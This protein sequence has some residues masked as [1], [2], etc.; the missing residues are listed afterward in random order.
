MFPFDKKPRK[1]KGFGGFTEFDGFFADFEAEMNQLMQQA[2]RF[3]ER[4]FVYGYSAYTGEDGKPVVNEYTNIPG[5]KGLNAGGQCVD[6]SCS[7]PQLTSSGQND[8]DEPYYDVLDEGDR[9]K[10][11]VDMPGVEKKDIK[12]RTHGRCITI[13]AAGEGITYGCDIHIPDYV[14]QKPQ[15]TSYKNGILEIT[16]KKEDESTELKID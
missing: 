11:I 1:P 5:Y 7:T 16:Y 13:N 9:I 4:S 8:G 6:G 15:K 10:I 2:G 12:L 3:P 14:G